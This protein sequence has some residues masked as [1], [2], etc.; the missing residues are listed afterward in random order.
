M[1]THSFIVIAAAIAA[2]AL[3]GAIGAQTAASP[4]NP[5]RAAL[6]ELDRQ[7]DALFTA[8]EKRNWN[9]AKLALDAARAG[10][11]T[12]R[13]SVFEG[14]YADTGGQLD[15]LYIARHRL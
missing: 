15:A 9:G 2:L 12:L 14:S 10:V 3:S 7:A 5:A 1:S 13:T 11:D 6:S 8:A 4:K